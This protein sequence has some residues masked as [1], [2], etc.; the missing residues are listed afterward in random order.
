[1]IKV[2]AYMLQ[3]CVSCLCP[4]HAPVHACVR[5]SACLQRPSA[6]AAGA[7]AG[8]AFVVNVELCFKW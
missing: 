3:R 5:A 6:G 8:A 2:E 7:T 4:R 1:M